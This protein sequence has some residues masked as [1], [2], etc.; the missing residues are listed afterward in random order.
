MANMSFAQDCKKVCDKKNSYALNGDVIE[1]VLYHDNGVIAQQGFYT[2]EN[3][4]QGEWVSFDAQGNKT[5]IAYYD[6]G[7]KV[8][9]WTF[10]NA[11]EVKEVIYSN[12]KIAKVTSTTTK[13]YR[14]VTN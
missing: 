14:I 13:D 6:K 5:A 2:K 12:S 1:A 11:N 4:L 7:K 10:Y 9:K 8:G 3:K